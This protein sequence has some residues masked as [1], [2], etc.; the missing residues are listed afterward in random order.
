MNH[1]PFRFVVAF[2]GFRLGHETYRFLYRPR[3]RTPVLLLVGQLD[4]MIPAALTQQLARRCAHSTVVPFE[5]T[6][7]VPRGPDTTQQIMQFLL[8]CMD[9]PVPLADDDGS[10]LLQGTGR[11]A[12]GPALCITPA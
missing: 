4:P 8:E 2:S 5:G 11:V 12:G 6:H 1:P 3:I 7:Y 10:C 9:D